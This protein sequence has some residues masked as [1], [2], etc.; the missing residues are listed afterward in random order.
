MRIALGAGHNVYL[1]RYFDPG[2]VYYPYVEA[3]ITKQT[4]RNLIPLLEAQGHEVFDITPYN[5]KFTGSTSK[6]ANRANH[7]KRS[8]KV[9][10]V[11]A[12]LYLDIHIN[13]GRGKGVE[14]FVHANNTQAKKYAQNICDSIAKEANIPNRGVKINSAYHTLNMNKNIPAII[15]E[16]GF[17]DSSDMSKLN[18]ENYARGIAKAFG[19]VS[20]KTTSRQLYRVRRSWSD[21]AT[22]IGAYRQLDNAVAMVNKNPSYKVYDSSGKVVYKKGQKQPET[23]KATHKPQPKP[24]TKKTWE[25]YITGNEV[26]NLQRELN[27]QFGAGL[28]VD[29]YFGDRT[30]A[31]LRTVR[32]GA[33]GN[34]TRIIQRRLMAKGHKLV[35]GAD[36]IFG[37]GTDKEVCNFQRKNKLA[38][39]GI[40]GRNTWKALFKK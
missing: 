36:G 8:R 26:R 20:S 39:D 16:G 25:Y 19:N 37:R 13:A 10:Q 28:K 15:I 21:A 31:A 33:T 30:I 11:K 4:V 22:Q 27:K 24:K 3:D 34:L 38:V 17:I 35:H 23:S 1:N 7:A 32:R 14:C 9:K 12:D 2:A 29:G 5:E 6:V 18:P 40:V